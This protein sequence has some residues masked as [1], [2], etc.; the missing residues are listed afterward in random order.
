MTSVPPSRIRRCN[1]APP[2][3]NG[4]F[5]LYWMIA[6]RRTRYNFALQ[7]AVELGKQLRRPLVV[8]EPLRVGYRWAS[9]RLH[10]FVLDGMADNGARCAAAGV[11]YFPYLEPA[12]GRG[13]G[14]LAALADHACA[15]VT[16]ESPTFFLPAMVAAAARQLPVQLEQVDGNGLLPLCLAERAYPTAASFRR[17]VHRH[18]PELCGELPL[19]D[20]LAA[21]GSLGRARLPRP[22]LQRWPPTSARVLGKRT[23][24]L[25]RRLPIDHTVAA[26][27]SHRGG[28]RAAERAWREFLRQRLGA[29]DEQR[30]HPDQAGASGLSPYLHFGHLSSHQVLAELVRDEGWDPTRVD[31]AAAGRRAG[32]WGMSTSA[33]AFVD[34]LVTWRELGANAAVHDPEHHASY[35]ALPDWARQTLADHRGDPRPYCYDLAELTAARTHDPVWNAAQRQLLVEGRI[36]NYLRM[37]W[38]KKILQWSPSPRRALAVMVELNNRFAVD[39]RDPNSVSGILWTLGKY[40]RP[41]G[42]E[43]PIFGKVRFMSSRN[44]LRK[45]KLRAY[46]ERWGS[47][48]QG[49]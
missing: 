40:D 3:P 33:E 20:P 48:Q 47:E 18:G 30:N 49:A 28:P 15:V 34:Q 31:L 17:L 2:R 13:Q 6:A 36:H 5:V 35:R 38:G 24:E 14:L 25:L 29:Y 7:R 27:A 10:R 41:W 32:F 19:V 4:R 9:E 11:R 1:D 22:V 42:P 8:L 39:G 21:A 16:D 37:L 43:R 23:G 26:V 46:L 12:P 44:T 45:L